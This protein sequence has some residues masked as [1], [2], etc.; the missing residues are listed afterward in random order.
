VKRLDLVLV[1]SAEPYE[2][3]VYRNQS[4]FNVGEVIDLADFTAEQVADL[5]GRHGTPLEVAR[6][7]G[8]R[9]G[10]EGM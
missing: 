2:F 3:I 5:N 6:A 10:A 9:A 1:T 4:P 8:R 7:L